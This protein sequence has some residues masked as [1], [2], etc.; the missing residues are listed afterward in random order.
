MNY[1]LNFTLISLAF[2]T[3]SVNADEY[4]QY[5]GKEYYEEDC[6]S[7]CHQPDPR[8]GHVRMVI[9]DRFDLRAQVKSCSQRFAPFW[10]IEERDAVVNYLYPNFYP[11]QYAAEQ[12]ELLENIIFNCQNKFPQKSPMEG[13][14]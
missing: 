6:S 1:L 5:P 4:D 3:I 12:V 7:S 8:M 14:E 13:D 10:E 9:L 2:L 11:V